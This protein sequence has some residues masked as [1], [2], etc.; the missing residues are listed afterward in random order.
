MTSTLSSNQLWASA[1]AQYPFPGIKFQNSPS[2]PLD[3]YE[4][5]TFTA[6]F[7]GAMTFVGNFRF[8]RVGKLVSLFMAAPT[9]TGSAVA[10]NAQSVGALPARLRPSAG[11]AQVIVSLNSGG[12]LVANLGFVSFGSDGII[13]IS[14]NDG[15]NFGAANNGISSVVASYT[16]Q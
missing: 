14:R 3:Y 12:A 5:G 6:N 4:D 7:T 13:T 15:A 10:L 1:T 16:I 9:I 11:N 8:T 2:T